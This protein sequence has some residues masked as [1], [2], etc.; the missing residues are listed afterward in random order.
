MV[1]TVLEQRVFSVW[2]LLAFFSHILRDT[3]R[4]NSVFDG[5]LLALHLATSHFRFF[6]EGLSFT[7]YVDHKPLTFAMSKVSDPWS[8]CQ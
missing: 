8:M 7:T 5:E 6:L 2:Q 4:K 3:E 1:G